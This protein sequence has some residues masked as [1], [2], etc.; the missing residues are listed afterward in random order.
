MSSG[1]YSLFQGF[2]I[3]KVNSFLL[4]LVATHMSFTVSL[5]EINI[6]AYKESFAFQTAAYNSFKVF[7]PLPV[8][9]VLRRIVKKRK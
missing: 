7:F 6:T 9:T 5:G 2:F 8:L 3:E 1:M 4:E